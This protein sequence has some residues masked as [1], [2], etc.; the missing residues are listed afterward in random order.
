MDDDFTTNPTA[1]KLP[2]EVPLEKQVPNKTSEAIRT[3][4]NVVLKRK[5]ED[6]NK[7]EGEVLNFLK[8]AATSLTAQKDDCAIF[9]QM[10]AFELRKLNPRNKAIAKNKIQNIIFELQL[11]EIQNQTSPVPGSYGD[12][13]SSSTSMFHNTSLQS[14]P[15]VLIPEAER[16]NPEDDTEVENFLA[17]HNF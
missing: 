14:S 8:T 4:R 17:F 13:S 7:E 1:S 10:V 16:I 5:R 6:D 15:S 9:G 12:T 3:R 2:S 11:E